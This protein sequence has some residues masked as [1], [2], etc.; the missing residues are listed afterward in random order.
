MYEEQYRGGLLCED[1]GGVNVLQNLMCSDPIESHSQE[2]HELVDEKYL[3]VLIQLRKMGL[4]KKEDIQ[5]YDLLSMLCKRSTLCKQDYFSEKRFRFLVEWDPKSLTQTDRYGSLPIHYVAQSSSVES[6]QLVFEYG[7]RYYPKDKGINLLFRT[8]KTPFQIACEK[9]CHEKVMKV[10]E[11]TLIRYSDTP[12]NIS[13]VL[14]MAAID[15]N[16]HLDCVYFLLRRE[17]D[18]L[19]KLLSSSSLSSTSTSISIS[20]SISTL[21]AAT[22]TAAGTND[23]GNNNN[24]DS[25]KRKRKRG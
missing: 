18:V 15:E 5:R 3:Q 4:L 21:A 12:I 16:I 13:E 14:V 25:K 17:P 8:D 2:H 7:I 6:F 19:V 20:I 11:D 9:L 24:I 22:V 23:S 10:I 1:E